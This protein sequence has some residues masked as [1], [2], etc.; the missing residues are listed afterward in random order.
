[1]QWYLT[2]VE[3]NTWK[4]GPTYQDAG[5]IIEKDPLIRINIKLGGLL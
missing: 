4:G 3:D 1:M 2:K 5:E